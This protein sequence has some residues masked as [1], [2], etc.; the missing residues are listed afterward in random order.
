MRASTQKRLGAF[1]IWVAVSAVAALSLSVDLLRD[2]ELRTWDWRLRAISGQYPHNSKVKIITVD[3]ASLDH[4]ASR[5]KIFWP[6]P[7]SLYVPV[8]EFLKRSGAKAVAFDMLFT[9]GS[10]RVEDDL[11]FAAAVQRSLPVVSTLVLRGEAPVDGSLDQDLL[12]TIQS[13]RRDSVERYISSFPVHSYPFALLP[14]P[15]LARASSALGSVTAEPD[16]DRIFRSTLPGARLKDIPVLNLPFALFNVAEPE[17]SVV[18]ELHSRAD[19]RGRLLVRFFGPAGTYDT[20]SMH[21][22]INSFLQL[23]EGKQPAIPLETFKD[24]YVLIGGTAPGL[25]DLRAV[26]VGGAYSGVEINATILDNLLQGAFL[27]QMDTSI[28]I[29]ITAIALALVCY[30]TIVWSQHQV[31]LAI[32]SLVGWGVACVVGAFAGWW[33]PLVIPLSAYTIAISAGFFLQYQLEGK[34]HRF[35]RG[36]FQHYVTAEV[37]NKIT[38][39]PSLLSLGG[40]RKELTMFFSDIAGFTT[41][42]ETMSPAE[43]VRFINTFLSEMT[44][45]ILSVEGT[46]DKYE[47]DAIIA[48]WNAPIA[49]EDHATRAVRAALACQR[50]LR[51][52]QGYFKAEFKVDVAMRV[53][54]NTGVVTV[55]NFGSTK[56]FNYTMI[57]DAANL[58]S[59]LEG[60]NKVFGTRIL[61]SE[62]TKQQVK[63]DFLWRWVADVQVKGKKKTTRL[64][65]PL[66]ATY[67]SHTIAQLKVFEAAMEAFDA[68][69]YTEAEALFA[70]MSGDPVSE[71]YLCR[72]RDYRGKFD[73]VSPVWVL[74]EK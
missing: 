70:Q 10:G 15:E 18:S 3:Q 39:D 48:F 34:Q 27:R 74:L 22:V 51:E 16:T 19:T 38:L 28:A 47:G 68:G 69:R 4:F 64:Y 54:I 60:T 62:A 55:G 63:G 17:S 61:V 37:V 14:T 31:I 32:V 36:A 9:E 40:D 12:A 67:Q 71:A 11:E 7:R 58:A 50:R 23:E 26:P 44:D 66:D 1:I 65:E 43:L 25:L 2:F 41:L 42:S 53:G 49:V 5:E 20:F 72:I 56:R 52:L 73:G 29:L 21:A 8:L 30:L 46:I 45:I 6:W 33:I 24:S 57:G 59:R 35:I 13:N